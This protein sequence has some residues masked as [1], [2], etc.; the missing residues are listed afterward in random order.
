MNTSEINTVWVKLVVFLYSSLLEGVYCSIQI[1][2]HCSSA[3]APYSI[4]NKE[5]IIKSS[6][7]LKMEHIFKNHMLHAASEKSVF[8]TT[9]KLQ[10]R[11]MVLNTISCSKNDDNLKLE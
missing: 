8:T 6:S 4:E 9:S 10:V 3:S 7:F 11:N 1:V 2:F 5:M